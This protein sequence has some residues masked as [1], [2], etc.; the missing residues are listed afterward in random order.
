MEVSLSSS[1][2]AQAWRLTLHI[3]NDLT[4]EAVFVRHDDLTGVAS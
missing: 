2:E 4:G 1:S 3:Q